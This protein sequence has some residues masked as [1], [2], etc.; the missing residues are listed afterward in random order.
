MKDLW[1]NKVG[2]HVLYSYTYLKDN[3]DNVSGTFSNTARLFQLCT[4]FHWESEPEFKF[5]LNSFV[6]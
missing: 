6:R 5:F 3:V 4:Y 2:P 1:H